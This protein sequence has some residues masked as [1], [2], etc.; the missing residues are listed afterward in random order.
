MNKDTFVYFGSN[1]KDLPD[2]KTTKDSLIDYLL[3]V[4]NLKKVDLENPVETIRE[5]AKLSHE[6]MRQLMSEQN[7]PMPEI[8]YFYTTNYDE[9]SGYAIYNKVYI[10]KSLFKEFT[11]H[12]LA[13]ELLDTILH[14]SLHIYDEYDKSTKSKTPEKNYF[15]FA[16]CMDSQMLKD[17]QIYLESTNELDT[18]E[19]DDITEN[20]SCRFSHIYHE[21]YKEKRAFEFSLNTTKNLIEESLSTNRYSGKELFDL[22]LLN[23]EI[24]RSI[25]AYNIELE[26]CKSVELDESELEYLKNYRQKLLDDLIEQDKVIRDKDTNKVQRTI[27]INNYINNIENLVGASILLDDYSDFPKVLDSCIELTLDE[28]LDSTRPFNTLILFSDFNPSLEQFERVAKCFYTHTFEGDFSHLEIF[29]DTFAAGYDIEFLLSLYSKDNPDFIYE[30]QDYDYELYDISDEIK[31]KAIERYN[32]NSNFF[33][34]D[35]KDN[36]ILSDNNTIV[37]DNID[38]SLDDNVSDM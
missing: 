8:K 10:S 37:L 15:Q 5:M 27:Y 35:L 21:T 22:R 26:E 7:K 14:E 1:H 20:V 30:L 29:V 6:Y 9:I 4:S 11:A 16:G 19:I 36:Q 12:E 34:E 25:K 33:V 2:I 28:Y 23:A 32:H 13:V 31:S 3:F 18:Y 24:D 38:N 17:F